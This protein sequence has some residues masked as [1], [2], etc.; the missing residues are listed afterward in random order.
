MNKK[1]NVIVYFI[2]F[3]CPQENSITTFFANKFE[4]VAE[5]NKFLEK[6]SIEN[7]E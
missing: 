1:G 3:N 2:V 5:M 4:N 7:F 6:H